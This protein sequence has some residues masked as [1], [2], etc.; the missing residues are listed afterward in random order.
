MTYRL[1]LILEQVL[2]CNQLEKKYNRKDLLT[3]QD[4]L[5]IPYLP[6]NL[7]RYQKLIF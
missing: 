6:E 5:K 7:G 4:F 3:T 2:K 1:I